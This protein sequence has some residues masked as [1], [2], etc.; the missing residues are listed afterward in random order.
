ML[1]QILKTQVWHAIVKRGFWFIS[2]SN[3]ACLFFSSLLLGF[4]GWWYKK[5]GLGIFWCCFWSEWWRDC[6]VFF[7]LAFLS[8]SCLKTSSE[9]G[10]LLRCCVVHGLKVLWIHVKSILSSQAYKAAV[11]QWQ[12]MVLMN[13]NS[14]SGFPLAYSASAVE[15]RADYW[16]DGLRKRLALNMCTKRTLSTDQYSLSFSHQFIGCFSGKSFWWKPKELLLV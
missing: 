1:P 4:L 12:I 8:Y 15:G 10:V 14:C 2:T 6:T 11:V 7:C 13:F 3:S 5:L 16:N 9:Y